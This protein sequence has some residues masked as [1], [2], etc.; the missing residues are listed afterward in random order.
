[1][2][3]DMTDAIHTTTPY[4]RILVTG[5]GGFLGSAI[6]RLLVEKGE[7]VR[8]YSRSFY[9][10][11]SHLEVEQVQGD[12]ADAERLNRACK[13]V[14]AVFHVAAKAGVWGSYES[15]YAPN[16]IGTQ[17][18]IA[19]CRRCDVQRLIYTSSPSVVFNGTDM[20]GMNESAPYPRTFHAHYPHTKAL[21]EQCGLE[22]ARNGLPA[23]VLRPHLIWGPGDNHLVP[24]I[25]ARARRLRRVGSG[26]NR[27][28]TIYIDNA[29]HAHV[30]AEAAL[31]QKPDI[32]G[33][34]YFI[35]Q[36]QPVA[37][38]D[39]IDRILV[40]GGK[41]PLTKSISAPVAFFAGALCEGLYK[42]FHIKHEPPM[43]R[44]VAREL[45]T[46]H[47]FAISAAKRDLGY[48]PLV[49][50][51]DGLQRLAEWLT[52]QRTLASS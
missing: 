21:A 24:R 47:W 49:S 13:Q 12:L 34:T 45:A 52:E 6:V 17:N 35:S 1:M 41:R 9:T 32:C 27:V 25:L 43:T 2:Q 19:A 48:R 11:L 36:D 31:K 38:W 10:H 37:L 51:E 26:T 42:L 39:M 33:R 23:V 5:G 40:A 29:A 46:A 50:L 18:V 3:I 22:A 16:V 8:T 14:E 20:E 7:R 30:L 28:D 4:R 15:F 44:F